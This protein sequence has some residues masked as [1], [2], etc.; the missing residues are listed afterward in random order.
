MRPFDLSP[1]NFFPPEGRLSPL[2]GFGTNPGDLLAHTHVP[3]GLPRGAPLVVVLHGCT[4]SAGDYDRG[5]GWSRLADEQV[6]A[7]LFPEQVRANN[8]NLC[9]NWFRPGDARRERGEAASIRQM[10]AHLIAAHGLDE[11]RVFVTGLSAGGAMT[12]VMLAAYPEVFAGGAII[13]GLPF[14]TANSIPEALDRMRGGGM[15]DRAAL[16]ALVADASPHAGPWP[17]LSI[18][19]GTAD[20]TVGIANADAIADQWTA[21]Q[22]L[23]AAPTAIDTLDG[24]RRETWRNASGGVQIERITVRGLGHGTPLAS[25]GPDGIG[26]P[27]AHMLE[28]G[29]NST[30]HIA[31]FWGIAS[32]A[33]ATATV[34]EAAP[35]TRLASPPP[36]SKRAPLPIFSRRLPPLPR[37]VA[38]V[39]EV[40]DKALRSAGLLR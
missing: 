1:A 27:G 26:T 8:P 11:Q 31:A 17:K 20:A 5:S 28:A 22:G 38:G 32:A 35:S 30:R 19:H 33:R 40:I 14:A 29:I 16:A 3:D 36:A 6:F 10:V 34:K 24:H 23:S 25:T 2:L 4:Q 37:K 18:W 39:A 12:A 15:P 7:V 9:F 21:L 13:A